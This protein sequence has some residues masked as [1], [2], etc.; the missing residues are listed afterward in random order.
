[1]SDIKKITILPAS[2]IAVLI[3]NY[4]SGKLLKR[5]LDHLMAQTW[6]NKRI[7]VVDN[8]SSDGSLADLDKLFP[9]IQF[10]KSETNLGFA[11]GNNLALN[12]SEGC[13]WIVLLNPDAFP[14]PDWLENLALA[15]QKHKNYDFFG[16]L[17][18]TADNPSLLD[19]T[20]DV[21]HVCGLSW[22]RDHGVKI[23]NGTHFEGE[24]FAPCAAAAMYRR[25]ALL[26]IGGFDESFFCY[27]EDVD[28]AFRLRLLGYKCWY[29]PSAVVDHI[30]SGITGRYS[31]F[32]T[33]HGHRNLVWTFLKNMPGPLLVI[34]LPLHLIMSLVSIL[35]GALRGQAMVIVR[36]KIDALR[37]LS[38]ILEKRRIIQNS[39]TVGS[40]AILSVL[41]RGIWPLIKR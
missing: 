24:I 17:M 41:S 31:E 4:N 35:V 15:S 27:H 11:A 21:L 32:S 2:Y 1:M 10:I 33:Y 13:D 16:C 25:S 19:G 6:T 23:E 9:T 7:I 38:D 39:R 5:S 36:A 22:R 12:H 40:L 28:L 34:Y 8:A 3:V 20:G 14:E 26:E 37:S 18:R 30:G 29:V